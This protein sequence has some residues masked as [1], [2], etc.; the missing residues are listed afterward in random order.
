[1]EDV[2]SYNEGNSDYATHKYQSWDF[3]IKFKL[4]CPFD[5]DICKRILRIKQQDGRE[6]DYKKII[7]ICNE[8]LRQL[9][10]GPDVFPP[11]ENKV[12]ESEFS[13]MV[14]DYKHLTNCEE[15]ALIMLISFEDRKLAYENIK[16]IFETNLNC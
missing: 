7:H 4:F 12:D 3:W 8:R 16:R 1:M 15:S 2:R 9:S 14:A 6:L 5:A 13:E 10:E 11:V